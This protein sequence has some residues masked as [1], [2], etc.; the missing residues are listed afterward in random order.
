MNPILNR[1]ERKQAKASLG[2]NKESIRRK[3]ESVLSPEVD[4]ASLDLKDIIDLEAVRNLLEDFHKLVPIPMGIVGLNGTKLI[5]VGSQDICAKFYRKHPESNRNCIESNLELTKDIDPMGFR[6]AKC[7]N[8]LWKVAMPIVVGKRLMGYFFMEQFFFEEESQDN[9]IFRLQVQRYGF[10]E[11]EYMTALRT[12]PRV[13]RE[14]VQSCIA[15]LRKLTD[16][17]SK[18]SFSNVLL[19]RSLD[20]RDCLMNSLRASENRLSNALTTALLGHW[21]YDIASDL[22]TF[23]DHFYSVMKTTAEREGGYFMTSEQYVNRFIHPDDRDSAIVTINKNTESGDPNDLRKAEHRIVYPDGK[24]GYISVRLFGVIDDQGHLIKTQGV[25]QDITERKLVEEA[26][27]QSE[28]QYRLVTEN[29]T[30]VIWLFDFI[31]N[32]FIYISPAIEKFWGFAAKEALNFQLQDFLTPESGRM[33]ESALSKRIAAFKTGDD[34]MITQTYEME[35]M[36]KNGTIVPIETV[37]ML[38]VNDNGEVGQMQGITR[39]ITERKQLQKQLLQAQ[40]M[41][42]IGRLAGGIAHDFNN[43]LTVIIG[44]S[45]SLLNKASANDPARESLEIIKRSGNRAAALTSKLLAFSRK[46]I[47][48]PKIIDLKTLI[49]DSLKIIQRLIGEDIELITN[50]APDLGLIKADST[51][52]EQVIMNLAVN[53]RDAMPR[54]GKLSLECKNADFKEELLGFK[55]GYDA[56][57]DYIL[58]SI[59]DTGIGMDRETKSHLF[60]PFFTTKGIGKGT[61]LGLATVYGII[62]QSGGFLTVDSELG[63]GTDFK[64]YLPRVDKTTEHDRAGKTIPPKVSETILLVEDSDDV[65]MLVVGYLKEMGYSVLAAVDG[66]SAMKAAKQ[67]AGKIDLLITDMI[68]PGGLNG[69]DIYKSIRNSYPEIKVLVITGYVGGL[70]IDNVLDP[71]IPILQK[72]F[73]AEDLSK[74]IREIMQ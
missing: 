49:Q 14:T 63:K 50:L 65:R 47:L 57:S 24:W 13:N 69:F 44:Y 12:V 72:P 7:K 32:R 27:K 4:L 15:F 6:M 51:Q 53:S 41:E 17:I 60:E 62:K 30:D 73:Y 11:S 8:N 46:Q 33:L 66:P 10:T 20:E 35:L 45:N 55:G 9:D 28:A 19:A 3:L 39:D 34:S 68:M 67:H 54:G 22:F 56:E 26:L 31:L 58:L 21:D 48:Q 5:G 18:L 40:K 71:D 64:I 74:K 52:I 1:I 70:A 42:A 2:E 25:I 29:T 16:T 23:N 43:I 59:S 36:R 38:I 37:T 61:G